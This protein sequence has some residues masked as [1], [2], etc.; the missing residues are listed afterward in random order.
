MKIIS[1]T[2][3]NVKRLVAVTIT[4][5]GNMVPITGKNG[6]GKTS[7]LD[8][9]WWA[10]AGA[11]NIQ[12]APIRKGANKALIKLDLGDIKV[13]R[14]FK[15]D[16]DTGEE[17]TA[18][19]VENEAGARF[20]SPQKML[21]SLL[22][23]LSF[24]PLAFARMTPDEQFESLR[25][26]VPGV[27]FK[28]IDKANAD[29][30]ARRTNINRRAKELRTQ[31]NAIVIPAKPDGEIV[32]ESA[33]V[34][35]LESAGKTNAVIETR[36]AGREAAQKEANTKKQ[37]GVDSRNRAAKIRED[38]DTEFMRA[39][40]AAEAAYEKAKQDASEGMKRSED[41]ALREDS[42]ASAALAEAAAIEKKIDEAEALP[43]PVDTAELLSKITGARMRNATLKAFSEA[44]TKRAEFE[45]Q[46]E[47][48]EQQS[49]TLTA[50]MDARDQTKKDAIAA[51]KLPVAGIE[52]GEGE[53][54]LAGVPFDQASDAEKLRT[55][56]AIAMASNPQLRVIRVRDGSLLDEDAMK[57]LAEMADAED[58]Q[59]WIERVDG[60]GKVG[61]VLENGY[62]KESA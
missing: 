48:Q 27:D 12:A 17:T 36:K 51:A 40:K 2:A 60:T 44:T 45:K 28:A 10:L 31:A 32:D 49:A 7:V 29:D 19:R 11:G 37:A 23:A 62:V 61:I 38:A 15:R 5:D 13:V 34:A 20:P 8:S 55:S 57:L 9:I 22:G 24:D 4:P 59:V 54:M 47:E 21:D 1:L 16:K 30:F 35:Q 26:F 46:A 43:K 39:G 6:A 56:V 41:A 50:T 3:E 53:I 58:Y 25:R 18:L 42:T 14:E 52:F 33:L